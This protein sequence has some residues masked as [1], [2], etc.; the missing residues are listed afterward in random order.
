MKSKDLAKK[1]K[2]WIIE[3]RREF[4]AYPEASFKEFQTCEKIKG[5]LEN[6]GLDVKKLGETGLVAILNGDKEGNVIALR[7]DIDALTV[8]EKTGLPFQS[9]VKGMMHACGHDCHISMLLGAA[10]MLSELKHELN[11]TVKFIFQPAEE[12]AKGALEM[13]KLGVLE[14]PHVDK[15]FTMHVWTDV[16]S[17][18]IVLEPG[19]FMASGDLWNLII[20]GKSC[21]GS[22]PWRGSDA[23]SC[24]ASVIQELHSIVTRVNDIREPI[25]INVG[26]IQGGERFNVVAGE[27]EI[28]GMNRAFTND[29]RKKLPEWMEELI[30]HT[31][32]AH[33]CEYEFKY[34]FVCGPTINEENATKE[35][36]E[37]VCKV[38]GEDN[39]A[40]LGKIMGSEDFS[41]YLQYV[42][43]ALMLLG[44]GNKEKNCCYSNHSNFFNVD[45]DVLSIG[46][47]CY[48]QVALDYLK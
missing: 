14:E 9:K 29:S 21:H 18:K 42:P 46:A 47:A 43:G 26:T 8:E 44:A 3:K 13:I 10:K 39:L 32:K 19:P 6:M 25:V 20:K 7:A 27:V 17:G 36:K 30:K 28:N 5:E 41:E 12:V 1:Y 31:C 16:P 33:G 4:H 48:T 2:N 34:E 15:I 45:E 22:S 11:G 35:I 23:I 37:S 24:A 38:V 40:N